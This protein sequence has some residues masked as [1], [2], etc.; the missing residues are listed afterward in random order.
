MLKLQTLPSQALAL[1]RENIV[2]RWLARPVAVL[3]PLI[4]LSSLVRSAVAWKHET[5]RYFPD[6]YIYAALG[7]SLAHGH[8]EIRG[9]LAHFPAIL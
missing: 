5:P 9:H 8:Y 4:V 7:R 1:P 3:L 6:E 2:A